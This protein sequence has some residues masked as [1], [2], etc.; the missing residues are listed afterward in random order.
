ML[1]RLSADQKRTVAHWIMEF[2][3]V[4]AG[5]LLALW[6]QQWD[7]RR[8][9]RAEMRAAEQSIHD[10]IRETLKSLMWRQA[11]SKCHQDRIEQLQA[12]LVNRSAHWPGVY[13]NPLFTNL[14]NLPA[15]VARSVYYRPVDT[16][17]DA[18]WTSALATGALT[19][20]DRE[21]FDTLVSVYDTIHYLQRT[22][23][24][25]DKAATTLSPMGWPMELTPQLRTEML[26]A[27][28]DLDRSR[29]TFAFMNA[30]QLADAMR[31]LGWDD[32]AEIDRA[33]QEN[34]LNI[35]RRG[36]NPR[37][38]VAREQN[39]FKAVSR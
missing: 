35:A 15:S 19:S 13:E 31:E 28:Y 33:I 9:E 11:I 21:H 7:Q 1:R 3:V 20:M 17:T 10:E 18:A 39:P 4:V 25:E 36:L 6:L 16:F 2:V 29:F 34:E 30:D 23:D 38:C 22:R 12:G 8:T 27:V 14:G 26:R 5:V 32:T 24:L 37:P